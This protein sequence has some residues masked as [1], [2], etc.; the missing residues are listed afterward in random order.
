[1]PD[2]AFSVEAT[3]RGRTVRVEFIQHAH[4]RMRQRGI[5][6]EDV[7]R[8]LRMPDER[9]L[10]TTDGRKRWGRWDKDGARRLDVV[11][12]EEARDDQEVITVISALWW[13]R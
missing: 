3:V 11:F 8:C 4:L 5:E 7:L 2:P 10:D 12:K 9:N 1:M 13:S 6:V